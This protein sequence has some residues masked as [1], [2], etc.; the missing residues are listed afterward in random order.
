MKTPLL[1]VTCLLLCSL[2]RC[3]SV[4]VTTDYDP[5]INFQDLKT[6]NWLPQAGQSSPGS[7]R[8]SLVDRRVRRAIEDELAAKG[9]SRQPRPDLLVMFHTGARE[10]IDVTTWGYT[11]RRPWT[12]RYV[13]VQHTTQGTIIIDFIDPQSKE[14]IWR[15][16]GDRPIAGS[17]SPQEIDEEIRHTVSEILAKFPPG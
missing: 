7:R 13:D 2:P 3:S 9:F 4:T 5:T 6:F 14:L 10:K 16:R 8:N 15:G 11:S 12:H 17:R 1:C